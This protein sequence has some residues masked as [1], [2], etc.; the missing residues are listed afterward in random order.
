MDDEL[1]KVLADILGDVSEI[2]MPKFL[3]TV[4]S[5]D[6]VAH[7]D[8]LNMLRRSIE[9][10]LQNKK[11]KTDS[12]VDDIK[13]ASTKKTENVENK[14][15]SDTFFQEDEN[16]VI[17]E[18]SK[19]AI[20]Q[21]EDVFKK[22]PGGKGSGAKMAAGAAVGAGAGAG[23]VGGLAAA[24]FLDAGKIKENVELLLSIGADGD[25]SLGERFGDAGF[26]TLA[27]IGLG[28]GLIAFGI[29]SGITAGVD[30]AVEKFTDGLWAER[31]K[32]NVET[33]LSIGERY[34]DIKGLAALGKD[35]AV[36]GAL[37]GLG[38]GLTSFGVGSGATAAVDA[39]SKEGWAER[40][41]ENVGMLLDIGE[42]YGGSG[43]LGGL[44]QLGKD[45][46]VPGA[47]IGLGAGLVGFSVGS[48]AAAVVDSFSKEGWAR[49]VKENVETLLSIGET[50]GNFFTRM[51]EGG[52]VVSSLIGLGAGLVAF[53]A[54]QG[55]TQAV[56][57]FSKEGW[58]EQVKENVETLLSIGGKGGGFIER[59]GKQGSV[60]S[61]LIGLGGGLVAFSAGQGATQ[62]V[63]SFS[64]EGWALKIKENVEI[65][66]STGSDLDRRWTGGFKGLGGI[67]TALIDLGR[68]LKEFGEGIQTISTGDILNLP[69][70]GEQLKTNIEMLLQIEGDFNRRNRDSLQNLGNGLSAFKI[71]PEFIKTFGTNNNWSEA[72]IKHIRNLLMLANPSIIG[73]ES[74]RHWQNPNSGMPKA[75]QVLGMSLRNISSQDTSGLLNIWGDAEKIGDVKTSLLN[76]LSIGGADN[77]TKSE[78]TQSILQNLASG[79]NE[80][81]SAAGKIDIE[82]IAPELHRNIEI[83][84]DSKKIIS[85]IETLTEHLELTKEQL[86]SILTKIHDVLSDRDDSSPTIINNNQSGGGSSAPTPESR[87]VFR[88]PSDVINQRANFWRTQYN[89]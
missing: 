10:T 45:A 47:L 9:S 57:S 16:V 89:G 38:I 78:S 24:A 67:R 31:V 79:L 21:L 65:L 1:N 11:P 35:G 77:L 85:T 53:S 13:I 18:F 55:A 80:F 60:V 49:R 5:L 30:A 22:F 52:T 39:F 44:K 73:Q 50:R 56:Q 72:A 34:S 66:L 46:A 28:K 6:E 27:L 15:A 14:K 29:G 48:G 81:S 40:T 26:V 8:I 12:N 7:R 54:G 51:A 71:D 83:K 3:A 37:T 87:P 23:L 61:A 64:K 63:Q 88:E 17:K 68:G 42:R 36:V 33:L 19:D 69:G 76:I 70:W 74:V 84:D 32:E 86:S 62:A 58:P 82:K 41:A 2:D 4:I 75:L 20:N 25:K 59:M 43:L